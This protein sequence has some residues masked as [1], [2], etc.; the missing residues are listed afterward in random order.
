[1]NTTDKVADDDF[2]LDSKLDQ[3]N[4]KK[5]QDEPLLADTDDRLLQ[6]DS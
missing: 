6:E 2:L 1:M 3:L 5:S 4:D